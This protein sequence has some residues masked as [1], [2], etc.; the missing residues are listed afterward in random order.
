MTKLVF[1]ICVACCIRFATVAAI[2]PTFPSM[3]R[4][5]FTS[6][7]KMT[8]GTYALGK[9]TNGQAAEAL[10]L[11]DGTHDHMCSHSHNSTACMQLTAF[12][13]RYHFFPELS[14]QDC[15]I[16]CRY[17]RGGYLCGGPVSPAWVSNSTGNLK[18]LGIANVLGRKCY[19]WNA[20]GLH[21]DFN[22][23]YQDLQGR[24]CEIDGYNY[25]RN[26]SERADDQYIFV[27]STYSTAVP[28]ELFDLPDVCKNPRPCG[29]P[30]CDTL[31]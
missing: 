31:I 3:F 27:P 29:P 28:P 8:K 16:C 20:V 4:S 11:E 14:P 21:G 18:Y 23:Y 1:S 2:L 12:G 7:W 10:Y 9:S 15:C 19:K 30:V 6:N 22:Y 13:A 24:P 25:L 17:D 5:N 26:P